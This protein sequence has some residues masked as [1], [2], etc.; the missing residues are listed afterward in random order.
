[1]A[2]EQ[3]IKIIG[4]VDDVVPFIRQAGIY[5]VPMR[6]GGGIKGKVL[7]AMACGVPVVATRRGAFGIK[8]R[9]GEEIL[10]GDS[11]RDFAR[12]VIRLLQDDDL[13]SKIAHQARKVVEERYGWEKIVQNL[14]LFYQKSIYNADLVSQDL[15]TGEVSFLGPDDKGR[16]KQAPAGS[17][18]SG[19]DTIYKRQDGKSSFVRQVLNRVDVLVEQEI[20]ISEKERGDLP[21][22]DPQELHIEL[23]YRCNSRCIMCDL[24]DYYK[25]FPDLEKKELTFDEIRR[26]VEESRYLRNV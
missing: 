3:N 2:G 13:H 14:D 1:L 6:L 22:D 15:D 21:G 9:P 16:I 5:I 11:A 23:T 24:W 26:F 10:I 7:E 17:G 8:A 20:G 12:Q 25:R 19:S 4:A 18:R